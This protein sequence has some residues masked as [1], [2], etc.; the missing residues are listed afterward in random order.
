MALALEILQVVHHETPEEGASALQRWLVDNHLGTLRL[1]ALHHALD[2]ALAEVVAVALH[3]EAV[4][5]DG[6]RFLFCLVVV[7]LVG[8]VVVA[9]HVEH[10]VGDEILAGAVALYDGLD[11]ILGHVGIVCQQLLV[12]FGRQ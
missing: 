3:R 6:A 2:A 8:I 12:S 7:V 9:S 1:D 10:A 11:Q 5:A 4:N